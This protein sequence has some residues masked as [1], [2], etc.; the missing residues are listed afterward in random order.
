ML[1]RWITQINPI[2]DISNLMW[3]NKLC[4]K[5]DRKRSYIN[6]KIQTISNYTKC[7]KNMN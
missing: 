7:Y 1:G 4:F 5:S 2:L 3:E 6:Y